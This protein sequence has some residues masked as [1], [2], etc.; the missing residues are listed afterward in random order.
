MAEDK[1]GSAG[2]WLLP[3]CDNYC[4]NCPPNP[5]LKRSMV[6]QETILGK[7]SSY[8]QRTHYCI[9]FH[10]KV[11]L[12]VR[13]SCTGKTLQTGP[14]THSRNSSLIL[15]SWEIQD[16]NTSRLVFGEDCFLLWKWCHLPV[17]MEQRGQLKVCCTSCSR[18]AERAKTTQVL[19]SDS[20]TKWLMP[21]MRA[22]ITW[23]NQLVKA[24]SL[25]CLSVRPSI[26]PSIYLCTY[27]AMHISMYLSMYIHIHIPHTHHIHTDN[28]AHIPHRLIQH[29]HSIHTHTNTKHTQTTY[30][31]LVTPE[32]EPV[33]DSNNYTNVQLGEPKGFYWGY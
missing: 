18:R 2:R 24:F 17:L 16:Q 8:R 1:T 27:L 11:L 32:T 13:S 12:L 10:A 31:P 14:L 4:Y 7:R 15:G 21:L 26:H 20:F 9:L 22:L 3:P 5:F 23:L 29:K 19:P 6:F 25:V 33:R 30:T 28:H